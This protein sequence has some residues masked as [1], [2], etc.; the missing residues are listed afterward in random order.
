MKDTIYREDAIRKLNS[1]PALANNSN[2]KA[3]CLEWINQVPSAEPKTGH[4]VPHN[5]IFG[6][7]GEKVYTCDRCGHNIGFHVENFCPNCGSYN[8]GNNVGKSSKS[9]HE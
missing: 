7:L 9:N 1:I 8:G 3:L 6:G 4:W 2:L 5:S